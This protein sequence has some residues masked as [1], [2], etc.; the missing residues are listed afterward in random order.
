MLCGGSGGSLA[1]RAKKL[2]LWKRL[3]GRE[4]WLPSFLQPL[5]GKDSH[6]RRHG[7]LARV[8]WRF[9]AR[10]RRCTPI[11][12]GRP[13]NHG[14]ERRNY[15]KLAK[16]TRARRRRRRQREVSSEA[17]WPYF[18]FNIIMGEPLTHSRAAVDSGAR[19]GA[20]NGGFL[21]GRRALEP[22]ACRFVRL[23]VI[24]T[25][26]CCGAAPGGLAKQG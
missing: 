23:I 10:A 16:A 17:F 6:D 15:L 8:A 4:T 14:R 2:G 26:Y 1:S 12:A 21:R 19:R 22:V 18:R 9:P 3:G 7:V 24:T 5:G 13:N 20:V 25:Y 11:A